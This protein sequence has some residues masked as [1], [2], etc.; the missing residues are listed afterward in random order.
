MVV[1]DLQAMLRS[2][3]PVLAKVPYGIVTAPAV[4]AGL[5]PFATVAEAEGL[6]VIAPKAALA[7]AGLAV[8]DDWALIS[9]TLHS[10]LAA[11][12]LTAAFAAA[13][14][15]E[16]ISANVI[17]GF[18][19]DHILVQWLRRDDATAALRKLSHA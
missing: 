18:H 1:S 6:T 19:H 4:P 17:A 9:L 16:G 11:V 5:V 2:M 8:A 15:A 14:G 10:D 13:L 3:E 7:A 12:G